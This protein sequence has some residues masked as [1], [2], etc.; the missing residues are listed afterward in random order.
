MQLREN[1]AEWCKS[2]ETLSLN[3]LFQVCKLNISRKGKAIMALDMN[4]GSL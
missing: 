2:R 3:K 1:P 4:V